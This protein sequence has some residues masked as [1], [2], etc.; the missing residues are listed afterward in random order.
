MS[1]Y[2]HHTDLTCTCIYVIIIYYTHQL[3]LGQVCQQLG[4]LAK[5]VESMSA[6][7]VLLE[8]QMK[9]LEGAQ[10]RTE[11]QPGGRRN[12]HSK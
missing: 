7:L 1:V 10:L 8:T 4:Q 12:M 2:L 5:L 3:Q 11:R 6:R 9:L